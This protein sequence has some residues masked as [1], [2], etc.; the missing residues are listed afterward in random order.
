MENEK[1]GLD[2]LGVMIILM[3]LAALVMSSLSLTMTLSLKN[4][5]VQYIKNEQAK[6]IEISKDFDKGQTYELAKKTGKPM[7]VMV[8]TDWCGVS[9]AAAPQFNDLTTNEQ[10]KEKFAIAYING[11]A[12]ENAGLMKEFKIEGYPTIFI[13]K[14]GKI[15]RDFAPSEFFDDTYKQDKMVKDIMKEVFPEK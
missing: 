9:V 14:D 11:D 3:S 6:K 10:I 12:K 5:I 7:I 15:V 4:G 8:Y 1:K 2:I 13:L